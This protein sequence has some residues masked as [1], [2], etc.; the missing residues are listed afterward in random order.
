MITVILQSTAHVKA[1]G[2]G[3][4]ET[5]E[6]KTRHEKKRPARHRGTDDVM[7]WGPWGMGDFDSGFRGFKNRRFSR[8]DLTFQF[9]LVRIHSR[10]YGAAN[11]RELLSGTC[12]TR[13]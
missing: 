3:S 8:L 13:T 1:M 12:V 5:T 6:T 10:Q 11:H 4:R 9:Q 2:R 7:S